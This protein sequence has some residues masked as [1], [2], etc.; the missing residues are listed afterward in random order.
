MQI[1]KRQ[2]LGKV[3]SMVCP[4]VV[5]EVVLVVVA[6]MVFHHSLLVL[7]TMVC[8]GLTPTSCCCCLMSLTTITR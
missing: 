3:F 6:T 4:M 7:E 5:L 2:K 8:Q 1:R